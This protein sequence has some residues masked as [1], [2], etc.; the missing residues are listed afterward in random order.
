MKRGVLLNVVYLLLYD[1]VIKWFRKK[2]NHSKWI[3]NK[4]QTP[5]SSL[6]YENAVKL[7][8]GVQKKITMSH[9]KGDCKSEG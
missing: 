2:W 9:T 8:G 7:G 1:D 4:S 5:P 6:L 3:W